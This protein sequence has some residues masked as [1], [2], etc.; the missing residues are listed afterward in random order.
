MET[1]TAGIYSDIYKTLVTDESLFPALPET[2]MRVRQ[3]LDDQ[4]CKL[5]A[6][7]NILKADPALTALIMRVANSARFFSA[8]P[9]KNLLS[10]L[11]RIGLSTTTE[12]VTAFAIRSTYDTQSDE[13]KTVLLD[14]YR[15]STKIA[16]ISYFLTYKVSKLS[17][18]KALLAGLMQDIAL[19]PILKCLYERPDIFNNPQR[20]TQAIDHLAPMVG[21]LILKRWGFNK[22]MIDSVHSRK[23]WLR[24]PHSKADLGDIILIARIHSMLGTPEFRQCPAINEIPAFHKLPLGKLTPGQ[25]LKIL[26]DAKDDIAEMNHLL[27]I[28]HA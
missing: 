11:K 3:V 20:R 7:A 27:D 17:P 9:P 10:A 24:D 14:S 19:P 15:Q 16:V 28:G 8:F 18:S 25:S 26:E 23:D 12:L 1:G 6:V 5:T 13:L 22:E 4:N 2:T 21:A